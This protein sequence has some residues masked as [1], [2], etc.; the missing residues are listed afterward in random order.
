MP[1]KGPIKDKSEKHVT[2]HILLG[3]SWR[4][5]NQEEE[6]EEEV[7]GASQIRA[8]SQIRPPGV[9]FSI[10][11]HLFNLWLDEQIVKSSSMD[12]ALSNFAC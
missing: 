2:N 7:E 5:E 10:A 3:Q 4:K 9:L 6:R 1:R 12:P 11:Q 8:E